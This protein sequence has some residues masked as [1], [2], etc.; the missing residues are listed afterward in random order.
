M[1]KIAAP[2]YNFILGFQNQCHTQADLHG[3]GGGDENDTHWMFA[4]VHGGLVR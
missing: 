2:L 1:A 4:R 3:A